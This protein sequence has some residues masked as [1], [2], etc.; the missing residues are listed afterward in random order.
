MVNP[1]CIWSQ[2]F[3]SEAVTKPWSVQVLYL[4][5]TCKCHV[6]HKFKKQAL[7]KAGLVDC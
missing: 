6:A 7:S 1:N 4:K 5:S 3:Y 2:A